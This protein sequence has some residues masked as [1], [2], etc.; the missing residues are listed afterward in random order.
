MELVNIQLR[1][2]YVNI[3][4]PSRVNITGAQLCLVR[5]RPGSAF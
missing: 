2:D 1:H 3:Y 4:Y 5:T